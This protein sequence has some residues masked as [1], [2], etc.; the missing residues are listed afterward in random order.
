[1]SRKIRWRAALSLAVLSAAV[2]G[3]AQ[4]AAITHV[5]V[6]AGQLQHTVTELS[7][8]V[9]TNT[10]FHHNTLRDERWMTA[11]AGRE[12]ETDVKTGK[13]KFDCQFRLTVVRCWDAPISGREPRAGTTYIFPGDARLLESWNDN[14]AAVKDLIGDPRGYTQTG[15]TTFLG[16]QAVILAQPAQRSPDGG[17][18]SATV[19]ADATN[20]YPLFR[21]DIDKDQ[22]FND[23]KGHAGKEQVD[24]RTTTKVMEVISPA[25]VKLTI[26][27]HP[28]AK[29]VNELKKHKQTK[30]YGAAAAR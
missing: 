22:P 10:P 4:A 9:S 16:H 11:T 2:P 25:G 27:A 21:E 6:P 13:V 23:R 3:A 29:V 7:W 12:I 26:G 1:M 20:F 17:I 15:T 28:H 19:I 18:A 24:E 14:G 5:P 30:G 8:P